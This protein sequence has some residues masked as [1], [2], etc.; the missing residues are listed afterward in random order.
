ML[1]IKK[2][3]KQ[4]FGIGGLTALIASLCCVG[5]L[6]LIMLGL[7]TASTALSIGAQKPYFLVLGLVF[8]AVSLFLFVKYRRKNICE[9][10]STKEQERKRI[11]NI[12]LIAFI[13]FITLYAILVYAVVPRLA[14]IVY[15]SEIKETNSI[16]SV[17]NLRHATLAIDGMTC[18]GCAAAAESALKEKAGVMDAKVELK[19]NPEGIGDVVY[20]PNVIGLNK[21]IKSVEPYKAK[22]INDV[23]AT[24]LELKNLAK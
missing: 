3:D 21:I 15:K 22:V 13:T 8:F 2:T 10:C 14:P 19:E 9:G 4:T 20:S 5:P 1:R 24:T 16:L 11:I 17:E 23:Q 7:G 12:V 18:P 6:V